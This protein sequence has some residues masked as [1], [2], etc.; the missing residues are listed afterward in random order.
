MVVGT[1]MAFRSTVDAL[2]EWSWRIAYQGSVEADGLTVTL[3]N[4]PILPKI[5]SSY[6]V[7]SR[8]DY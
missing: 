4:F 3:S 8:Q 2:R 1:L 5:L 7:S 6:S